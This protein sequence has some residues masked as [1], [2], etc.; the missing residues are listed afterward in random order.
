MNNDCPLI[1]SILLVMNG[2]IGDHE[3]NEPVLLTSDSERVAWAPRGGRIAFT[4]LVLTYPT[5]E[6]SGEQ[7]HKY[8]EDIEDP[9]TEIDGKGSMAWVEYAIL[10]ITLLC[11][12]M[13]F[14]FWRCFCSS[15]ERV[16]TYSTL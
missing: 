12:G 6:E 5:K 15:P 1:L 8:I 7:E 3:I 11:V 2:L 13:I 10:G 9:F 4:L 16:Q 14:L